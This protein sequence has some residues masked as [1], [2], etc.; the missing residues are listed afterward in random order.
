MVDRD[1]YKL[2]NEH[3]MNLIEKIVC[4]FKGHDLSFAGTCPYTQRS[5]N[6]CLRCMKTS[7]KVKDFDLTEEV[8]KENL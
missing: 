2:Y 7:L 1:E 5:Y 4:V 3:M 8:D 6:V